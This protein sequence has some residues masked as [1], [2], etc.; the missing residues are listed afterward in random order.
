M[1]THAKKCGCQN[2]YLDS[3]STGTNA[4]ALYRKMGF[5]DTEK[6]NN[7]IFPMCLW[8]GI[9]PPECKESAVE[10]RSETVDIQRKM[11]YNDG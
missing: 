2:I 1:L 8:Y 4:V 3:L 7:S 9:Y 11:W 6:Y 10:K 5:V